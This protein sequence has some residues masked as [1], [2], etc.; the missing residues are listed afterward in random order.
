MADITERIVIPEVPRVLD[1]QELYVYIPKAAMFDLNIEKGTG[2]VLV[3]TTD[4][5]H[6]FKVMTDGRAK[7]RSA[8]IESDD[9]VRKSE[10]DTKLDKGLIPSQYLP[11]YVD[12]VLE[13][14]SKSAFPATGEEGKIYVD[15]STNL[16]YRWS[17]STY[18][19][20]GGGDLAL[21]NGIGDVLIQTTD[22]NQS[23]KVMTD[24]RAKVQS[25]PVDDDDVVRKKELDT[26]LKLNEFSVLT[27]S[28]VD[29]LF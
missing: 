22:S 11:S 15:K 17:G 2:N 18:I 28:Q 7:V 29:L 9:V 26:K 23:F 5:A 13:Y 8:P 25:A 19:Q 3:Q 27:Q 21:E 20:V 16:T 14:N 24:G 1:G 10:L 4:P 6:S 12:D